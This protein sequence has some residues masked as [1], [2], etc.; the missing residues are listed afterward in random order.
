MRARQNGLLNPLHAPPT[1]T[2]AKKRFA[3]P[4]LFSFG[5]PPG[6]KGGRIHHRLPAH[7]GGQIGLGQPV[8]AQLFVNLVQ[9]AKMQLHALF[10]AVTHEQ[11]DNGQNELDKGGRLANMKGRNTNGQGALNGGQNDL[12]QLGIELG[13]PGPLGKGEEQQAVFLGRGRF[14]GSVQHVPHGARQRFARVL[15]LVLQAGEHEH[16]AP[17]PVV[18]VTARHVVDK[19]N[20]QGGFVVP[21]GALQ[22]H[23]QKGLVWSAN[24]EPLVPIVRVA[25]GGELRSIYIVG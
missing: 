5:P 1:H 15:G 25:F 9:R 7:D 16:Q 22:G 10:R 14:E 4:R 24:F 19:A 21:E 6:D 18:T 3:S 20:R 2:Q 13:K 11:L 8:L 23:G 12:G 17:S